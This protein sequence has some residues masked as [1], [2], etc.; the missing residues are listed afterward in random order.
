[1]NRSPKNRSDPR[2]LHRC[3]VFGTLQPLLLCSLA[4]FF[5]FEDIGVLAVCLW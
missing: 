5:T 1:M 3:T 2:Q 4:V